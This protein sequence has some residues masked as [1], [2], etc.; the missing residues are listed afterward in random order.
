VI[1]LVTSAS[2][3]CKRT[4]QAELFDSEWLLQKLFISD[5]KMPSKR[6]M[7]LSFKDE[8]VQGYS[9]CNGFGGRR[10][11]T[12]YDR[13]TGKITFFIETVLNMCEYSKF[14]HAYIGGLVRVRAYESDGKTL[15]L[16]DEEGR[17]V[18]VYRRYHSS[19]P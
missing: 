16:I 4:E 19:S 6:L 10:E 15:T 7:M 5:E 17:P 14:E 12:V 2:S 1:A 13:S 11:D 8:Y 3:S 18:A 9:G